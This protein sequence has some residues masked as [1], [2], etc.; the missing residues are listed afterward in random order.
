DSKLY[1]RLLLPQSHGFPLYIPSPPDDLSEP[2][3]R[4]GVQIGDVGIVCGD[5]SF[6][7]L[8]NICYPKGDPMNRFGVPL[9]FEQLVVR[10]E[11]VGTQALYYPPGSVLSNAITKKNNFSDNSALLSLPDG[12][13][14]WDL[15]QRQ[16]FRNYALQH[17][18]NWYAF[19]SDYL[20]RMV[21]NSSL[22]L[23]TGVTKCT[24][25]SI[26]VANESSDA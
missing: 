15:H 10:P 26:G 1:S 13:S 20:Q 3:R 6:D 17:G 7:T 21:G 9:G 14:T 2:V 23:V 12:A 4:S 5:G 24:S 8:F 19:A 25:W 16:V 22:Y 18:R 11:D